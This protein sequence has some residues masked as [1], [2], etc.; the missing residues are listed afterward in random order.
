[1]TDT[2]DSGRRTMASL[3]YTE[4]FTWGSE[5]DP[6]P[7]VAKR[8]WGKYR[9]TVVDNQDPL[10][11]GR[12]L[13]SVPGIVITNWAMPCVPL[14]DI[15]TGTFVRPGIDSNVWV[16]FERGDPDKPIWVGCWWGEGQIPRMAQEFNAVP[17]VPAITIESAAAGISI[18]DVPIEAG[19]D[20]PGNV[21][22]IAGAGA[23]TIALTEGSVNITAPEVTTT[24]GSFNLIAAGVTITAENFLMSAL[25]VTIGAEGTV[26]VAAP[27]VTIEAAAVV[28]FTAPTVT[29]EAAAVNISAAT[30]TIEAAAAVNIT[31][32]EVAIEADAFTSTTELVVVEPV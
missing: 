10:A 3:G 15:A 24:T 29:I 1:M 27:M 23:V 25:D 8:H 4:Q 12:L 32:P 20:T 31:A 28:N 2:S 22:I 9:G 18:C 26:N 21:N 30:M 16:E 13:V 17:A 14:A 7:P 5:Q 11:C 6:E 19:G